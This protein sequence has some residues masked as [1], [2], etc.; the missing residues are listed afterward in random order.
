MTPER[1]RQIEDLYHSAQE[2]GQGVLAGAEPDLRT[3]V[4]HL[5]E[6]DSGS[7]LLDRPAAEFFEDSTTREFAPGAQLGHY[8]IEARLDAGGMGEVFRATDTR[9]GRAVAIK[10]CFE[11]FSERFHREARAI[12][13]LN[14]PHICTLYDVGPNYLVMELIEGETLAGRLKRGKLSIEQVISYGSQIADA[15]AAAQAKGIV[16]RDLKPGNIMLTEAGVKVLDFGLAKCA[17]DELLTKSGIVMGTPA[18]MSPEQR[19]GQ[20]CDARTDIYAVGLALYEMATGKRWVSEARL[21]AELPP[22]LARIVSKCLEYD[23]ALRYQHASELRA[24]LERLKT[25]KAR[26]YVAKLLGAIGLAAAAVLAFLIAGPF[27]LRGT[28][29]LTDKDT[30]VL[31]DFENKTGDPVFDDTLRQGLA[32]ALQQSPFLSFISEE[33]TQHVLGMMGQPKNAR[34]TPPLAREV[35][36]RAGSTAV[37]DGSIAS[38]GN[39]YVLG[40]RAKNCRTGDVL[41]EEQVQAAKKEGVLNA[42]SQAAGKFRTRL[43]ESL[44]TVQRHDTPLAEATTPSLEALKA[45]STGKRLLFSAGS[46][47]ALPHF[48][49]AIQIDPKFAIVYEYLGRAYS[50]MGESVLSAENTRR[51][52]ELRERATD[53]EQF[54]ITSAYDAQVTGNIEKAAQT[55]E[56]LE[57]AYPRDIEAAGPLSGYIYPVLAK[58]EKTIE[59]AKRAIDLDPHFPYA[60]INLSTAYHILNRLTEAD[61]VLRLAAK[62]RIDNPEVLI[63]RYTLS[64]L[65]GDKAAMDRAAAQAKGTPIEDW[66]RDQEASVLAYSGQLQRATIMARNAADLALPARPEAAALY[67]AGSAVWAALSG[68]AAARPSAEAARNLSHGRDIEYGAAFT[69]ALSGKFSSA[70]AIADDLRKRFP[71]DTSVQ[72]SYLPVL[73]ALRA[74]N[75][76]QPSEAIEALARAR[77]EL[78]TPGSWFNGNFGGLYPVYV[79][80]LAYLDAR[81]GPEAVAEFQ[82]M[83]SYRGVPGTDPVGALAHLQLG[84]AL[85]LAGDKAKA[86]LAYQ[87]FL[88]LWKDADPD[89]PVWKQAKA[90]Y[91]EL[92]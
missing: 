7:G 12:S 3:E 50:D 70:E 41:D 48:Q 84:R 5:L 78:G 24:D 43:G 61:D 1:W 18:Y 14:H 35:C 23:R 62:R 59:Q 65:E 80:G 2:R 26:P 39:E 91:A 67:L 60:Y 30:V 8:R 83:I 15:L 47:D 71:E 85:A 37:I 56:L 52:Y 17:H 51:A 58:Y 25:A 36:E 87:D 42:L 38:L 31:A 86:K 29:K 4:E 68:S 32:V 90:E 69:F 11:Q 21:N 53:R 46:A 33:R 81:Q 92:R 19:A 28:P 63:E 82:K 49:R 54:L 16:H 79:R 10:T 20:E 9:L 88:T 6:Q 73:R 45:F 74:L 34:L 55:F 75:H 13:S 77:Y 27:H 57:Q 22:D 40:L 89:I 66:M 72:F 76:G 64:F 44:G